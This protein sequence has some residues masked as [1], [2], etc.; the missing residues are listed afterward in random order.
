VFVRNEARVK[1]L[2]LDQLVMNI[3]HVA[4]GAD[5]ISGEVKRFQ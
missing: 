2:D 1:S 4:A 3:D 5:Q